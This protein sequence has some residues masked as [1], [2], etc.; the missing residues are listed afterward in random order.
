M[1]FFPTTLS[2]V[3]KIIISSLF[4]LNIAVNLMLALKKILKWGCLWFV[5]HSFLFYCGS[6]NKISCFE[7]LNTKEKWL[8]PKD[9]NT[10]IL[11][12]TT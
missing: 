3:K 10:L 5:F 1:L 11:A 9:I 8:Q 2:V 4:N 6:G 12:K 7:L